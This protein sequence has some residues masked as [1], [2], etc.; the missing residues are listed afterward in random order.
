MANAKDVSG[1]KHERILLIGD[2]GSGKSTQLLTLP[3]RKFVYI[4]DPNA[5]ATYAGFDVDYETYLPELADV[6][7]MPRSIRKDKKQ[8]KDEV[9]G[10]TGGDTKLYLDWAADVNQKVADGFFDDYDVVAIDSL[11]LW[12]AAALDRI[13]QLQ[14]QVGSEDNRTDYRIAGEV[15]SNAL[16]AFLSLPCT[17]V[18]MAHTEVWQD[19]KTHKI[20]K[21][22][23]LH[24]GARVRVPLLFTNIW[25]TAGEEGEEGYMYTLQTRPDRDNPIVRSTVPDLDFIED[26]TIP[27]DVFKEHGDLTQYGIGGILSRTNRVMPVKSTSTAK[28]SAKR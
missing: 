24:G 18:C 9:K 5:L 1:I 2:T 23:T 3:G 19:D 27:S 26:V 8:Y 12:G 16:R 15:E 13:G 4:F 14:E 6:D 10:F 20:F 7:F 21:R 25:V 22:I 28:K 11:T 17:I